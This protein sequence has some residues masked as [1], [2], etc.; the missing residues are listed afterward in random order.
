MNAH[1]E[2]ESL[3]SCRADLTPVEEAKLSD[4]LRECAA[5]R[6]LA[7]TF[8]WQDAV[9]R[10]LSQEQPRSTA[11]QCVLAQV[12]AGLSAGPG[13]GRA[14]FSALTALAAGVVLLLT[15]VG[16]NPLPWLVQQSG[17]QS[18]VSE[19]LTSCNVGGDGWSATDPCRVLDSADEFNGPN[20]VVYKTSLG[21]ARGHLQNPVFILHKG[22]GTPPI[23]YSPSATNVV[24]SE[25][26]FDARHHV[27]LYA[28]GKEK[29]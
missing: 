18:V 27:T 4:H 17:S 1:Q 8:A 29:P 12:D 11:R 3:L 5:C 24:F 2:Y 19:L 10:R 22:S 20:I 16:G 21:W 23:V 7:A 14:P 28:V 6:E 9:F 15:V 13:R 26:A 25:V